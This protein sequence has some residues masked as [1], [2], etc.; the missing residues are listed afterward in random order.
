MKKMLRFVRKYPL[1]LCCIL[2]IWVLSLVPFF[3][4]TPLDGID[5][6]DKW[7]HLVMYGGT[8]LVFWWEYVRQTPENQHPSPLAG[9]TPTFKW[10]NTLFRFSLFTF[11]F[12]TAM[13]GLLELI[14]AHC[15]TTRSG[16]WLDFW[17][18]GAGALLGSIVGLV[19]SLLWFKARG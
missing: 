6:V 1:S 2:L 8:A 12:L 5:F 15:T 11:I 14:Q 10:E 3:P 7:T 17:A 18:D 13:G 16:E 9:H 19:T 4:E